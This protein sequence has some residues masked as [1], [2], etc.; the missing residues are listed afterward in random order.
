MKQEGTNL[1]LPESVEKR[2][3]TVLFPQVNKKQYWMVLS[4]AIV[5]LLRLSPAER[6]DRYGA[7][8]SL[9]TANRMEEFMAQ[10]DPAPPPS[11]PQ[12]EHLTRPLRG[13]GLGG[14]EH[15]GLAD[16][17]RLPPET[18]DIRTPRK[19]SRPV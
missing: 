5:E 14:I 7:I 4:A 13:G 2:L 1:R 9:R 3:R 19:R 8:A 10:F 18:P 12:V 17:P 15:T 6:L 16:E 11:K